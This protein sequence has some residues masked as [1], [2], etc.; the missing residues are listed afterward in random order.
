MSCREIREQLSAYL[1]GELSAEEAGTI[2]DH[3]ESCAECGQELESLRRTVQAVAGLPSVGA[4]ADLKEKILTD[5]DMETGEKSETTRVSRRRM[6][7]PTA[8]AILIAL[9]L[10]YFSAFKGSRKVPS[11]ESR[12]REVARLDKEAGVEAI[13]RKEKTVLTPSGT[14][15]KKEAAR[16]LHEEGKRAFV[17]A[18]LKDDAGKAGEPVLRAASEGIRKGEKKLAFAKD[19]KGSSDA[20]VLDRVA[21]KLRP[22][23]PERIAG[24]GP[25]S[26]PDALVAGPIGEW[27][28]PSE[29]PAQTRARVVALLGEKNLLPLGK[30]MRAY[31][32]DALKDAEKIVLRLS[33]AQWRNLFAALKAVELAPVPAPVSQMRAG[34]AGESERASRVSDA[35]E[36]MPRGIETAAKRRRESG[37]FELKKAR[38]RLTRITLAFPYAR[39]KAGRKPAVKAKSP[40]PPAP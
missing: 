26:M 23:R 39:R 14:R 16:R 1:D 38:Q 22:R 13:E 33:P 9:F 32:Y 5:L 8:A 29:N 30:R 11:P 35:G 2:R 34:G 4:P 12:P 18:E 36:E 21:L 15:A 31:K 20:E 17:Q 7:W 40:K 27:A 37:A 19:E 24:E 3:V 25:A 28:I 10:M 6:L